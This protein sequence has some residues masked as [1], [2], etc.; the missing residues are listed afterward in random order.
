MCLK[1]SGRKQADEQG[2]PVERGV[3]NLEPA[4]QCTRQCEYVNTSP[5][6]NVYALKMQ[7]G[8][9]FPAY[10]ICYIKLKTK[11]T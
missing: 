3:R 5:T 10:T 4:S 7:K 8:I 1:D 2:Y 11:A 6:D 9:N